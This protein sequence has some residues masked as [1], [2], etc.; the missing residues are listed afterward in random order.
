MLDFLPEDLEDFVDFL[1][2]HGIATVDLKKTQVCPDCHQQARVV[3]LDRGICTCEN[4]HR[5][6]CD[7][8]SLK[9]LNINRAKVLDYV[10]EMVLREIDIEIPTADIEEFLPFASVKLDLIGTTA[11]DGLRVAV[12]LPF[13]RIKLKEAC[14]LLGF[15]AF[16]TEDVFFILTDSIDDDARSLLAFKS[17]GA[18]QPLSLS[19]FFES[20]QSVQEA[21]AD[22][23]SGEIS[24]TIR[25]AQWIRKQ[26]QSVKL[27]VSPD[28]YK[29][30]VEYNADLVRESAQAATTGQRT[31]FENSVAALFSSLLPVTQF[32]HRLPGLEIPDGVVIVPGKPL[33][34]MFYDAKT[35]GEDKK[36][37]YS[38]SIEQSDEDEFVRYVQL[39]NDDRIQAE[40]VAGCY[41][42]NDFN[43]K[44]MTN[45]ALQI[46]KRV[47]DKVRIVFI[48]L[49]SLL[50]LYTKVT[51]QRLEFQ[52]RFSPELHVRKLLGQDLKA[53][54]LRRLD[55]E[56]K[57]PAYAD[58]RNLEVNAVYVIEALVDIFFEDVL[59][60]EPMESSFRPFLMERARRASDRAS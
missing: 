41:V 40:L 58:L 17:N 44:N 13:V 37:V 11:V 26:F 47:S 30:V 34:L 55:K 51:T 8:Y 3:D 45:K 20:P 19:R 25:L 16:M 24:K 56:K 42:A 38:R 59:R 43:Q 39:F 50:K 4:G 46:R 12:L 2:E 48:P 57:Y 60:S 21:L 28:F 27:V 6:E 35:A 15:L 53:H 49:N 1:E 36:P 5:F 31:V 52:S 9:S 18:V 54:E 23:T 33:R 32:G 14:T 7:K 29:K 22:V 10:R